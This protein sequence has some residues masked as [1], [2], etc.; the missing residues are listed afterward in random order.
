MRIF[1]P[2]RALSTVMRLV[3]SIPFMSGMRMSITTRSARESRARAT[4][5]A[6]VPASAITS[7]GARPAVPGCPAWGRA[8]RPRVR[9]ST[10]RSRGREGLRRRAR[11][12]TITVIDPR[13]VP[14]RLDVTDAD[15]VD[16]AAEIAQDVSVVVNNAD[17]AR[18]GS[19]LDPDTSS[20][21]L[22]LDTNLFGPLA[23][24]SA[25]ADRLAQRSG[26][27]INVASIRAL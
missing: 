27:V 22:E 4:A 9:P 20:L 2:A 11:P 15:S 13:L 26:V 6:S 3:A 7:A 19:V 5:S 1:T 10:P 25:F 17:I 16:R 14:L 24:T 23:V 12:R 18:V 8:V 21:R